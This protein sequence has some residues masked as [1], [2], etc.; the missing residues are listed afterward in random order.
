MGLRTAPLG[1]LIFDD[2]IVG[3]DA[4]M[5]GLGGGA[6][7]FTPPWMGKVSLFASYVGTME[8]L[9]RSPSSM[10][11]QESNSVKPSANSKPF[12]PGLQI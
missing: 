7:I 3:T 9:W 8:R 2:V 4:V 11:P 10:L 5:G 1:E 12:A 6:S